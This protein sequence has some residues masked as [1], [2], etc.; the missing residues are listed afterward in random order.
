MIAVGRHHVALS[1][2]PKQTLDV[3]VFRKLVQTLVNLLT[4]GSQQ[5]FLSGIHTPEPT[6]SA[7]YTRG[8]EAVPPIVCLIT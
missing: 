6:M 3:I 1:L 5:R 4:K 8:I 2:M 7:F